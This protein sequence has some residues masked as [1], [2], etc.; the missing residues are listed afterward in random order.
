[1][2]ILNLRSFYLAST[3]PRLVNRSLKRFFLNLY[4]SRVAIDYETGRHFGTAQP[5]SLG[6]LRPR[7]G[8][9]DLISSAACSSRAIFVHSSRHRNVRVCNRLRNGW[10]RVLIYRL[11]DFCM[12]ARAHD[13]LFFRP[14]RSSFAMS[15]LQQ[16]DTRRV[17]QIVA[18]KLTGVL[19]LK[20]IEK[21][22]I[23]GAYP[24][25][26]AGDQFSSRS[27]TKRAEHVQTIKLETNSSI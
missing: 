9:R 20:L 10:R 17:C 22:Y 16:C 23:L 15:Y 27:K 21:A 12:C 19:T 2:R 8:R 14:E 25:R 11:P 6:Y 1:M 13:D 3:F 4:D 24:A 5:G 7:H 18:A 26:N